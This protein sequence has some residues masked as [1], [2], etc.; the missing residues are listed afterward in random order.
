MAEHTHKAEEERKADDFWQR[1]AQ[2]GR[3]VQQLE[4]QIEE[5][6]TAEE[7]PRQQQQ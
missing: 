5:K 1:T 2:Q 7:K 3:S 4:L 6:Q